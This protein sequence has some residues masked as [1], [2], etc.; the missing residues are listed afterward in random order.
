MKELSENTV[1]IKEYYSLLL[2][3][4]SIAFEYIQMQKYIQYLL[5]YWEG[6]FL[7]N[8]GKNICHVR[9]CMALRQG[10]MYHVDKAANKIAPGHIS[11]SV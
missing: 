8:A 9:R 11:N 6:Y 1:S 3:S 5:G 4:P 2:G 7:L 10:S